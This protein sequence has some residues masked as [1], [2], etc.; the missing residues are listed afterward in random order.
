MVV[1]PRRRKISRQRRR[2]LKNNSRKR[3][4]L[5]GVA[6]KEP[7]RKL[8]NGGVRGV[9]VVNLDKLAKK[10]IRKE[11]SAQ[12]KDGSASFGYVVQADPLAREA[13]T[14]AARQRKSEAEQKLKKLNKK[15]IQIE[16]NISD[17]LKEEYKQA[18]EERQEA[19]TR[20]DK[21]T[22][23]IHLNPNLSL[24]RSV[25]QQQFPNIYPYVYERA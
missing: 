14:W 17:S 8:L 13:N 18:L 25:V 22:A 23:S 4:V 9:K 2:I 24:R 10:E 1:G 19:G 15:V 20:G 5:S 12:D 11:N 21:P 3:R 7:V 6:P 16:R